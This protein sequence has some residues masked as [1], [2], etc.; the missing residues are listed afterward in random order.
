MENKLL[1]LRD[2][3][4][5]SLRDEI[6]HLRAQNHSLSESNTKLKALV[7]SVVD[8]SEGTVASLTSIVRELQDAKS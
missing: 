5:A 6:L 1:A 4:I 2:S 7:A 8:D 3:E